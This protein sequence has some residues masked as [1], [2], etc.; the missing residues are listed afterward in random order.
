MSE[1]TELS[2]QTIPPARPRTAVATLI[3]RYKL[4]SYKEKLELESMVILAEV[5][6]VADLSAKWKFMIRH[7]L[8]DPYTGTLNRLITMILQRGVDK[9][10]ATIPELEDEGIRPREHAFE[11]AAY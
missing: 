11:A 7:D 1:A 2:C 5:E 10:G 4:A 9:L 6:R 3:A 8:L